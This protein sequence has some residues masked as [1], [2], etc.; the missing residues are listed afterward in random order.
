MIVLHSIFFKGS[1]SILTD[2][3]YLYIPIY[4]S[5]GFKKVLDSLCTCKCYVSISVRDFF[6]LI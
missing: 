3:Y 5:T 2:T 4:H 6:V 1:G